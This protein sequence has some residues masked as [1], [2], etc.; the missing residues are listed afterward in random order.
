MEKLAYEPHSDVCTEG[1]R[2]KV[3]SRLDPWLAHHN[4]KDS[5]RSYTFSY[6]VKITN[7]SAPE[8]VRLVNRYWAITDITGH[9]QEVSGPGV[10]GLHPVIE[11][12]KSYEYMS[13]VHLS[14]M[15]GSMSGTYMLITTGS[16][17]VFPAEVAPF[18][19]CPPTT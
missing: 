8:P 5:G 14:H 11:P 12:G 15:K 13:A 18:A 2:V 3:S 1:V 17:R 9:T 10:V 19:L 4:D 7:E 6:K 16:G